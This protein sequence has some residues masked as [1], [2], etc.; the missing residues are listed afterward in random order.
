MSVEMPVE[1]TV[2]KITAKKRISYKGIKAFIFR[3][4]SSSHSVQHT[5]I[6]FSL[7]ILPSL[8]HTFVL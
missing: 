2:R 8:V 7:D 6:R 1:E 5:F 4:C 3:I